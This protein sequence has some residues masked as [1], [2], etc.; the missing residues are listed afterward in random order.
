MPTATLNGQVIANAAQTGYWFQ[1]G[2]SFRY[3]IQ[4]PSGS[5]SGAGVTGVLVA[6]N[7]L[8]PGPYHYRTDAQ[9]SAGVSLGLNHWA[10]PLSAPT[11]VVFSSFTSRAVGS[12]VTLHWSTATEVDIIGFRLYRSQHENDGFQ[13]IG[14]GLIPADL[15][16]GG[17]TYSYDDTNAPNGTWYYRIE[18]VNGTGQ[19][20]ATA[21]PTSVVVASGYRV[22]LPLL[23][24]QVA[25]PR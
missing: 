14:A 13:A 8:L 18:A 11:N 20:V 16:P 5:A 22:F 24:S 21:G 15:A 10:P 4:S 23:A 2:Q 3:G 7:N 1:Y 17:S 12:T 25:S 6:L 19:T 9:N